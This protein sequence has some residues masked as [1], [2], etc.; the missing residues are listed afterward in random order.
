M[1]V[2]QPSNQTMQT[3]VQGDGIVMGVDQQSMGHIM[4]LLRNAYSDSE[5]AIVREYTTNAR[6][7][8]IEADINIPIEVTTPNALSPFLRIR[9]FGLGLDEQEIR[10]IYSQYGASTK[11]QSND[12][13]GALGIGCKSALAYSRQFTI[14]A[15]KGGV[16]RTVSVAL[17]NEGVGTMTPVS[18]EATDEPTG[19]EVM[20]PVKANNQIDAKARK[21]FRAWKPGTVLLNGAEPEQYSGL[22]VGDSMIVRKDSGEGDIIVMGNVPYPVEPGKIAHSLG[23][24]RGPRPHPRYSLVAFVNIGEVAFPPSREALDYEHP[25]TVSTLQALGLKF[26]AGVKGAIQKEM[27]AASTP[28]D[29]IAVMTAY[30]QMVS[31]PGAT[32]YSYKGKQV[33][34]CIEPAGGLTLTSI[35]AGYYKNSAIERSSLPA[36]YFPRTLFVSGYSL[37]K[38][39]GGHKDKLL[40]YIDS[41][42]KLSDGDDAGALQI[43]NIAL[44]EEVPTLEW[45]KD[46]Q[47]VDWS[48][49][50]KINLAPA[51]SKPV[52]GGKAIPGSYYVIDFAS[53]YPREKKGSDI[54]LASPLFHAVGGKLAGPRYGELIFHFYPDASIVCLPRNREDK[55]VRLLPQ[56]KSASVAVAELRDRWVKSI[57]KAEAA[58]LAISDAGSTRQLLALNSKRIDD[59]AILAAI[60]IAKCD[61]TK[62]REVRRM[63]KRVGQHAE[64][65]LPNW[66][67]PLD[68]YPLVDEYTFRAHPDDAYI[69][70]NAA[71]AARK[72][73]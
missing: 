42:P 67:D 61:L 62:Q 21:F 59:P 37:A 25:Q 8:H 73:G 2:E 45:I 57:G 18:A 11:R 5:L 71:Y 70:L 23:G 13:N 36:S 40:H 3:N 20:I 29:A 44:M 1:I 7:A 38:F 41:H 15:I 56:S 27:D 50:R 31:S 54:D 17:N 35:T 47:R 72:E 60:R 68:Q 19:V 32:V 30:H 52:S 49:I 63:F 28:G 10:E 48:D 69:Y 65:S 53:R 14:I 24:V 66:S 51:A 46:E 9:D 6:D 12:Y 16:K 22:K 39:T 34:S 26:K 55:Y 43:T 58:A 4:Y 33:P 64:L